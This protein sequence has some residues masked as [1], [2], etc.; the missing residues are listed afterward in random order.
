[1]LLDKHPARVLVISTRRLGDVL[2]TT[3][4]IRSL[5]RTFADAQLDALVL[6][7]A[8]PALA[9]NPDLNRVL[10]SPTGRLASL[11]FAARL[12]RRYDLALALNYDDRPHILA[13]LA[14]P[15]RVGVVPPEYLPGARWKRWL[16]RYSTEIQVGRVHTVVQYLQL[17]DG[18]GIPR[19]A[20]V[21]PPRPPSLDRLDAELGKGW[22]T[23]AYAVLHPSP[24]NEYKA[25]TTE[26]W[27]ALARRLLDRGLQVYL[28]GGPAPSER[29][30]AARIMAAADAKPGIHNLAGRLTFSDLTPLLERARVYVGPDTSVTH[31]AAATGAPVIA[32][33]GPSDPAGW[34]PWP[35]SCTELATPWKRY[36]AWQQQANVWILQGVNHCVPCFQSGCERHANS[37]SQ[38]LTELPLAR[39]MTAVDQALKSLAQ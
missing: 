30:Y 29:D 37:A 7:S 15:A 38:C 21:V 8:A 28:S 14:A 24:L 19:I 27:A 17:A 36:A 34:G 18:L 1:M 39:V 3:P 35:K 13:W 31:I 9:G 12:F 2:L 10:L 26:N 22:A 23:R 6:P 32:L 16:T 11:R 5:R 4:L 25:W 20:E 33:F